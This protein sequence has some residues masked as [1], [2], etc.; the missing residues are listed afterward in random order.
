MKSGFR[1][2]LLFYMPLS[3]WKGLPLHSHCEDRLPR[4]LCSDGLKNF[5]YNIYDA[6]ESGQS[7]GCL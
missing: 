2:I 3:C 1:V 6:D 7:V 4:R 5:L